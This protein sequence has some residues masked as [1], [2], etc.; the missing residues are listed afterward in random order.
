M[1]EEKI[2]VSRF[3]R[4]VCCSHSRSLLTLWISLSLCLCLEASAACAHKRNFVSVLSTLSTLTFKVRG[5]LRILLIVTFARVVFFAFLATFLALAEFSLLLP[6]PGE[7]IDFHRIIVVS[8]HTCCRLKDASAPQ[9]I[10]CCHTQSVKVSQ[11]TPQRVRNDARLFHLVVLPSR[12]DVSGFSHHFACSFLL[13]DYHE[14]AQQCR[15]LQFAG[16]LA[17]TT[18]GDHFAAFSRVGHA[19]SSVPAYPLNVKS[20]SSKSLPGACGSGCPTL[21]SSGRSFDTVCLIVLTDS[22]SPVTA[23]WQH[24]R[25]AVALH[26]SAY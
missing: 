17:V 24:S 11:L 18:V 13:Y 7:D 9:E 12:L 23:S 20:R 19:G 6:F 25:T 5:V 14:Q 1:I 2:Q 16:G 8:D 15:R 3:L 26:P 22:A 4:R 10:L 21:M